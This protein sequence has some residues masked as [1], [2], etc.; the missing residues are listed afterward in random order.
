MYIMYISH[1]VQIL[2]QSVKGL[3]VRAKTIQSLEENIEVNLHYFRFGTRFLGV[4][5]K[6]KQHRKHRLNWIKVKNFML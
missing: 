3:N 5:K 6:H 1:D 2:M 4:T